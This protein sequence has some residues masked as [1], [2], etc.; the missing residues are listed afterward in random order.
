MKITPPSNLDQQ[1]IAA[2]GCSAREI[3][4][5]LSAGADRAAAALRPFLDRNELPGIELARAI[6]SDPEALPGIRRI[7]AELPDPAVPEVAAT[8]AVTK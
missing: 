5:I 7:Y 1:L 3:D 6:A 8:K 4:T 2:T